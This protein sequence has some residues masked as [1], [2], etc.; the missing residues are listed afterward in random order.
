MRSSRSREAATTAAACSLS[1]SSLES[2]E[3]T[4]EVS[5]RTAGMP[6]AGVR[7]LRREASVLVMLTVSRGMS[8]GGLSEAV[9]GMQI[10]RF[11][12]DVG[13]R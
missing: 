7:R 3:S 2:S 13:A 12:R 11:C 1:S 8:R 10:A 9:L 5:R 6:G 4:E